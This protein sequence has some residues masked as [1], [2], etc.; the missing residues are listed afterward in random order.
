VELPEYT[1]VVGLKGYVAVPP[2][3]NP[4][5]EE[6]IPAPKAAWGKMKIPWLPK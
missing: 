6:E 1:P 3:A 2:T 5:I 4:S